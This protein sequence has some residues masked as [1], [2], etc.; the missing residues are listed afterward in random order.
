MKP[1]KQAWIAWLWMPVLF[2]CATY[3]TKLAGYYNSVAQTDYYRAKS[4][5]EQNGFL[6]QGRNRLLYLM[7]KGKIYHLLGSYDSSNLYLN[8][9]DNFIEQ[10]RKTTGDLVAGNLLNPMVQTYLGEDYERFLLHYYKALNYLYKG[11]TEEALVEARRISLSTQAQQDKFKPNADRYT[12]DAFAL[13]MQG[14]IY[15]TAGETNNA[16]ISYR[17]ATDLFLSAKGPN[18]YGVRMPEQ[19]KNDLFRTADRMGFTDQIDLY[20]RKLNRTYTKS[21]SAEG[22]ELVLFIERGMAPE[23]T[24]QNFVL[25]QNGNG[26]GVFLFNSQ[27]GSFNV[28]FDFAAA[29]LS[30]S[31][32][33]LNE[34]RTVRVALPAYVSRPYNNSQTEV[35]VNGTTYRSELAEDINTLA[36]QILKERI[37]KEVTAAL[38]RQLVKKLTEAGAS[39]AAKELVK[40]NSKEKDENKKKRNADAAAL[41]AGLLVNIFNTATEKADTRNWRSLPAQIQ[42]VRVPLQK[43]DNQ[44]SLQLGRN[45]RTITVGGNGKLQFYNWVVAN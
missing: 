31:S 3:N 21:E 28:P 29:R 26:N 2:S 43:G 15:E 7:E 23:K 4:L 18:Y 14:M 27:Y 41:T 1:L 37:L 34:F 24:E 11:Q 22:G 40:S 38:T 13:M 8:L 6:Q 42:Y 9:A 5:L 32:S 39:A 16:F 12:E 25:M 17:N 36:P 20:Q 45:T 19:L 33:S 35:T 30:P 44:V 10:K